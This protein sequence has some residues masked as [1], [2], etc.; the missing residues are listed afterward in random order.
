MTGAPMLDLLRFLRQNDLPTILA[1][2]RSKEVPPA[3]QFL[4]YGICGVVATA[5]HAC[6]YLVL[7][8]YIWE[9]R[10]DGTLQ[11]AINT[12]PPTLLAFLF[13]NATVYFLNKKFVFT[14]GRHSPL[15]E[16]LLFTGVNL[17]GLV[18]GSI[19]QA[20][21]VGSWGWPKPM[22][23]LGFVLPNIL[24]NFLCRKLFIF[25]K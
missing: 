8:K 7:V 19:V 10:R 9:D 14:Q 22:A 20:I 18:G 15:V 6:I 24:I 3:I 21:L 23:L 17:P 13:S 1:A 12:L 5:V 4:K 16:F 11:N 2:F 25:K